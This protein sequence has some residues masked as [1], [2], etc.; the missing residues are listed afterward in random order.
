MSCDYD[1]FDNHN[2]MHKC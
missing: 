1:S 2:T